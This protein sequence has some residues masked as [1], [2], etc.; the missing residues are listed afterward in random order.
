MIDFAALGIVVNSRGPAEQRVPC[1]ACQRS[2]RDD[3]LG[4]NVQTGAFHCFRCAWKGNACGPRQAVG[5]RAVMRI[6]DPAI[7]ERKRERLRQVWRETVSLTHPNARAVRRYL[8]AR[9][10]GEVLREAPAVLRAH[11]GIAYWDG[12]SQLGTFPAMVALFH[13]VTG[14][15]VTLHVTYLRADGCAKAPVPSPKKILGVPV[16]GATKGGAIHLHEPR[17]GALG[18]AE[19]IESALSL[20]LLKSV[21]VWA[22]FCADNLERARLPQRLRTLHIAVDLDS[23]GKGEQVSRALAARVKRWSPNTQIT[24]WRPE[25]DGPGDLND[26][27]LHRRVG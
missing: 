16:R 1:P 13:G 9:A 18:I 5:P 17:G 21:P 11:P 15:P 4:V 20:H 26:E 23:S 2:K 12:T 7:A 19:G 14:Q 25:I 6:N 24:L 8:D 3:A 22:S 10:L 27:L